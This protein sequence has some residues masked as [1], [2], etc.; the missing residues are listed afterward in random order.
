[1]PRS[2]TPPARPIVIAHRGASAYRPEHTLEAYALA[3]EQGA[4]FIEP[5]LVVT[6]DGHLIARHEP[7]LG[8]GSAGDTT[9]VAD[10][11]T[12]ADRRKTV[13]LDGVETTGWFAED[14]TLAEIRT[15]RARERIPQIRPA[16]AAFD[17]RFAV[18]TLEE[19]IALVGKAEQENGRRVGIYP[20]TKHPTYV[21]TTLRL[22]I[23]RLL[24]DVL[25]TTGFTD[26]AR[27]YIQSFE[28]ENLIRLK[29]MLADAGMADIPLIQL[30]GSLEPDESAFS[31]PFDVR[32]NVA[33][34]HDL[35][36]IYGDLA[37]I[38]G[39]GA[40]TSYGDLVRP[41]SVAWIAGTYA[42]GIG[43]WKDSIALRRVTNGRRQLTGEIA[44]FARTARDAR[45]DIHPYTLR[46]ETTFLSLSPDGDEMSL[47]QEMKFLLDR[48]P[49]TGF[50][51]DDTPAALAALAGRQ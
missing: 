22:D 6:R 46:P 24:V 14:F 27:I 38:A 18:P 29:V 16:N 10:I 5:D 45:L 47:A 40:G 13:L 36:A 21:R 31:A 30:L 17:D 42:A 34:G 7:W 49:I 33:S 19:I 12:Y 48:A 35:K 25:S 26:P 11:P 1:M 43:P 2:T 4:D 50:F 9:N 39:L 41:D 8:N 28:I 3:I 15:L 23:N 51:S 20:E 37:D 32:H 44:P